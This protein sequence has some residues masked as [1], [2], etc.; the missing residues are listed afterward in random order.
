MAPASHDK[1]QSRGEDSPNADATAQAGAA[2]TAA[3]P[4]NGDS[5]T[6][7]AANSVSANW[8]GNNMAQ[9]SFSPGEQTASALEASL[10]NLESKLDAILESL[11]VPAGEHNDVDGMRQ[12]GQGK[13]ADGGEKKT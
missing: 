5:S 1:A 6:T 3:P 10:T 7:S 9:A 8:V 13:E 12:D 2:T 4:T 11:G